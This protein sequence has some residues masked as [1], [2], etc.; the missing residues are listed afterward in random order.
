MVI[1]KPGLPYLDIGK[2]KK[3]NIPVLAYQVSGEYT[4]L[5]SAIQ[6]ITKKQLLKV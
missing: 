3:F 2:I 1:V 6:K 5:K 4:L